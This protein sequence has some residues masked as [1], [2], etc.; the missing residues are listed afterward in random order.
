MAVSPK[1]VAQGLALA[2]VAAL[3]ALLIWKVAHQE[4]GVAPRVASGVRV[5]APDFTLK[6]LDRDGELSLRSL[7]G[8]VVVLNFWQTTCPPCEDEAPAFQRVWERYRDDGVV[9]VGVDFWDL[10][11]DARRFLERHGVTYPQV[12]DGPG[13]TLEPYGVVAAP[14]TFF[15]DR[16]GQIVAHRRGGLS[17]QEL[18]EHLEEALTT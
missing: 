10:D 4:S 14:E 1:L 15:I 6:R 5:V 11:S 2:A 8:R 17:E 12:Y 13:E 9:F 16:R 7:R 18:V 3:L